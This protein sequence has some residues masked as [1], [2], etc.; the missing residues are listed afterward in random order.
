[1]L[2]KTLFIVYKGA[3]KSISL[4][5]AGGVYWLSLLAGLWLTQDIRIIGYTV[6]AAEADTPQTRIFD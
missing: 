5:T 1:M 2:T 4:N 3:A 6:A